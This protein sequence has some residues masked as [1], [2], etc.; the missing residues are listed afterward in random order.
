MAKFNVTKE[1]LEKLILEEKLSY[2]EIGRMYNISGTYVK[3]KAE[4]LGIKL[5]KRRK[6]NSKESFGKGIKRPTKLDSISDEDF[7]NII[8]NN[9]NWKDII[10]KLGYKNVKDKKNYEQNKR[11]M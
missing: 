6:I 7:I 11:K 1:E 2:E 8:N 4:R 10:S 3:K 9:Y 5:Q